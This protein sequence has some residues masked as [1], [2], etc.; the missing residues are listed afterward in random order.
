MD[1]IPRC[2]KH[3]FLHLLPGKRGDPVPGVLC[4]DPRSEGPGHPQLPVVSLRQ[5]AAGQTD[6]IPQL[7]GPGKEWR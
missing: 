4:S 5:T 3:T 6:E 2:I 7:P 1:L